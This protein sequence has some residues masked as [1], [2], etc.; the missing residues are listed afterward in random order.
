MSAEPLV[1][2]LTFECNVTDGIAILRAR[3][4]A[5]VLGTDLE[6][7]QRLFNTLDT[8]ENTDD[9]KAVLLFN[10]SDAY[11]EIE[12]VRYIESL[13]QLEKA[14]HRELAVR[15][16]ERE[17]NAFDQ[18]LSIAMRYQKLI[19]SCLSG[20]IASPFFGLCLTSDVRLCDETLRFQLSHVE[21]GVPPIGGLG[22][23][24]PKF[25]GQGRAAEWLLTGGTIKA[26]EAQQNG[27]VNTVFETT[28]FEADC[29]AWVQNVLKRGD[30]HIKATRQL[31]Y[32]DV[33]AFEAYLKEESR[34]RH[35]AL[36]QAT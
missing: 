26:A 20:E 10:D 6:E 19:V 18:Y 22:Y 34:L 30:A 32:H 8:L 16:L 25:V 1:N 7:K 2:G 31:L 5:F 24:L 35:G 33:D 29:V 9:V 12:H 15:R 27:L 21:E 14:D 23:L 4:G 3:R 11:T 28:T 17:D 36:C 13:S